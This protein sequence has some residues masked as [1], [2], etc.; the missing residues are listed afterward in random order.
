MDDL[1]TPVARLA[2]LFRDARDKWKAKALER[3]KRLR[4]A[5]VRIRDL[6]QSRA[7]WKG[8]ALAAEEQDAKSD[9]AAKTPVED[10]DDIP[11]QW[12]TPVAHHHHALEVMQLSLQLF[13]HASLGC[14]GVSGVLQQFAAFLPLSVPAYTTVLNWSYRLGLAVLQRPLPQHDDWIFILDQ[15]IALGEYKCLVVLGIPASRLSQCGFSPSHHDMTVLA[16]EITAHSTGLWVEAVLQRVA[17]RTGN[18]VQIVSDH[19]SDVRKGIALFCQQAPSVVA[20]YDISHAVATQLKAHWRDDPHWQAFSKQAG[21]TLSAYQQTDLAFLLPPRQRTKARYMAVEA[22]ID[23]AQRLLAYHDR[24]DFSAIGRPCVFSAQAWVH[25]RQT[26]GLSVVN[27]LRALIGH[28]YDSRQALCAALRAQAPSAGDDLDDAFWRLADRSY[29]RFLEAFEWIF[30]YREVVPLWVQTIGVSKTV[31]TTLKTQGLSS[32]T[33]ARLKAKLAA[34]ASLPASV[35]AFQTQLL[36]QVHEQAAKLPD[37]AIWLA[38]SDI[39]ESVFGH[40]KTFTTRG[41][42]KEVGRLVLMI[43]AFLTALT[44]QV[45]REAMTSVR[46]LD[47]EQWVE[48]HLGDSM[49]KRRR[50]ALKPT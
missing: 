2:R 29:A 21:T 31:Q 43:P 28:R 9:A 1:K 41:P 32:A 45:I 48:T 6:E 35:A 12:G 34:P 50:Q 11:P 18:P 25:L 4:A 13:L 37:G 33:P 46:T 38:S 36:A 19:G 27:P 14:R 26:R 3:Q 23:W 8:R 49:L 24:G 30:A 42:L 20:T 40:Y 22:Q 16:V 44:P 47:V 7:Y 15:T 5:Q 17:A 10:E 39:I